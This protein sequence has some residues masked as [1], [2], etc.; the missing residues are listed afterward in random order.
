MRLERVAGVRAAGYTFALPTVGLSMNTT[1]K[2]SPNEE[3][4]RR[5]PGSP[6]TLQNPGLLMASPGYSRAIG[7][8]LVAG[9][10]LDDY[11]RASGRRGLLINE[12]LARGR[13]PDGNPVG[14]PVYLGSEQWEVAGVV[15]DVWQGLDEAPGPQVLTDFPSLADPFLRAIGTRY[16]YAVRASGPPTA[17]LPAVRDAVR[18]LDSEALLDNV[19][20][21]DDILAS[22]LARPRLYATLLGL[23]AAVAVILAAIGIYG[24]MA[25]AVAQNTREIGLRI[26]LG[27]ERREVLGLILGRAGVLTAVGLGLGLTL[28]VALSRYLR[29]MIFGLTP[30]DAPTYVAMAAAFAVVAM[31][32]S[33][34]P[35]RRAARVDPIVAL[36]AE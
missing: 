24:V 21:M 15:A 11:E 29:G 10:H 36:R 2:L 22:T 7:M 25:Y 4:P 27:A 33:Y 35:A 6:Y 34:V 1:L 8:R 16:Y 19:T 30:L 28:A 20:P 12:T 26:A 31:G 5:S 17:I 3:M 9:Q 18:Q 14:Q 13:F 32:A 23:F